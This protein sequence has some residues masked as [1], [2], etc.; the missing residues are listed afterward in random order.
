MDHHALCFSPDGKWLVAAKR[1][2]MVLLDAADG[3]LRAEVTKTPNEGATP[4]FSP[5]GKY[6]AV[7][8]V[9]NFPVVVYDVEK[10]LA[11]PP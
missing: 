4:A 2:R 11:A 1:G 3:K 6:L 5:D 8:H 7:V 10:L 9:T